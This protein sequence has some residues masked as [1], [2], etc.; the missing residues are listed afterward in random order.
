MDRQQFILVTAVALFAAFL[1]G[2]I[3]SWLLHRLTRPSAADMGEVDRLA[4]Q[5]Q[6]AEDARAAAVAA[7]AAREAAMQDRLADAEAEMRAAMDG[8]REPD[9][10]RGTARL[11][12]KAPRPRP[13]RQ[14]RH[15]QNLKA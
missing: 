4:R 3:A 9:L 14:W 8:L 11:Y 13:R 7:L 12:R 6:E 1:L 10:G 2:W 5:L 15:P